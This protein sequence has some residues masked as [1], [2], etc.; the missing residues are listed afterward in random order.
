VTSGTRSDE[1]ADEPNLD[2]DGDDESQ[3]YQ[4]DDENHRMEK[5]K[6]E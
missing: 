2:G 1:F 4:C 3:D 5:W 6:V